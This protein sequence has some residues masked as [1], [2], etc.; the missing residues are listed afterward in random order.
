M[1]KISKEKV[2]KKL[3][4][5]QSHPNFPI[6]PTAVQGL[7]K[8][9]S[10]MKKEVLKTKFSNVSLQKISDHIGFFLGL[11]TSVK[12]KVGIESSDY[13]VAIPDQINRADQVGL[14]KAT[15]T[16][17]RE[18]QLTKKYRFSLE[19]ILGIL[20]HEQT[21]N[22]LYYYGIQE[23]NKTENEI[24]TDVAAIYLGLGALLLEGYKPI[25]WTS[26]HWGD[27]YQ[28][29]YTTNTVYIGYLSLEGIRYAIRRSAELRQQ[30]EFLSILPSLDRIEVSYRLWKKNRIEQKEK[31]SLREKQEKK[32]KQI[33]S[34]SK[35]LEIAKSVH[36]YIL[37]MMQK[38]PEN[39]KQKK[40]IAKD[41]FKLAEI[42]NT[43]SSGEM[44][45]KL[46]KYLQ[47]LKRID[48]SD[49]KYN[50]EFVALFTRADKLLRIVSDWEKVIYKYIK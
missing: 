50:S 24:L 2:N 29:G 39:L 1:K 41:G 12:I 14:Y 47:D 18:I 16:Y 27:G 6:K 36:D 32:K 49:E 45:Y 11:S 28:S 8:L 38:N 25:T 3:N 7:Y 4:F 22:Y 44:K 9:P 30:K 33:K 48:D 10:H 13:M 35:R 31:K 34:L 37:D 15:G 43:L 40:I 21:H 46:E 17:Q 5:L 42:A 19:H 20:A 26:D 23:K